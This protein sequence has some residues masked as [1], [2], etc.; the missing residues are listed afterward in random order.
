MIEGRQT[1]AFGAHGKEA[2]PFLETITFFPP[3]INKL[4]NEEK[5]ACENHSSNIPAVA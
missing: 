5:K 2:R 3:H 4:S 1:M